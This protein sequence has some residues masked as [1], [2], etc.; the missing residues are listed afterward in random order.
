MTSDG[1]AFSCTFIISVEFVQ[2]INASYQLYEPGYNKDTTRKNDIKQ[3]LQYVTISA[4][5][6]RAS[7]N[8]A[9]YC[10]DQYSIANYRGII[11][12]SMMTW[13]TVLKVF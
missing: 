2:M 3:K 5:Y 1:A 12:G 7:L 10:I 9:Q 4:N 11:L 6:A 8:L 13:Y